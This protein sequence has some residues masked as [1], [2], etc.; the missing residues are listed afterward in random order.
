MFSLPSFY[1]FT[2]GGLIAFFGIF[3]RRLRGPAFYWGAL[4]ISALVMVVG[5]LNWTRPE[6]QHENGSL[7]GFMLLPF[8]FVV[9]FGLSRNWFLRYFSEEPEIPFRWKVW[10]EGRREGITTPHVIFGLFVTLMPF[11]IV[12]LVMELF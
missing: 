7:A 1:V 12:M 4:V 3:Y 5:L 6:I 9:F 10:I 8:L 2:G 11:V